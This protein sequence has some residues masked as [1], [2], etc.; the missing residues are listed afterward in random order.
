MTVVAMTEHR[1]ASGQFAPGHSGNPAGRPKGARNKTT[2]LAEALLEEQGE[3]VVRKLID[4][5]LAGDGAALR[6]LVDRISPKENARP[7]TLDLAPGAERNLLAV[8]ASTLRAMA[9]GEIT[10]QEA[11][12][13]GRFLAVGAK[14][15]QL[16]R[17]LRKEERTT[18][19][20]EVRKVDRGGSL[21]DQRLYSESAEGAPAEPSRPRPEQVQDATP[22]VSDLYSATEAAPRPPVATGTCGRDLKAAPPPPVSRLYSASMPSAGRAELYRSTVLARAGAPGFAA[23]AAIAS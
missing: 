2:L 4:T 20:V 15:V 6:F 16:R 18:A 1:R 14:L 11:L 22:P 17:T 3:A 19:A 7:I 13:I 8:H 9:D 10:P 12:M 21:P 23:P 5:A